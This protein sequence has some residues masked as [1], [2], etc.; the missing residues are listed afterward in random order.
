M[1]Q[2]VVRMRRDAVLVRSNLEGVEDVTKSLMCPPFEIESESVIQPGWEIEL[3]EFDDEWRA[4]GDK[5]TD[6]RSVRLSVSPNLEYVLRHYSR[7]LVMIYAP[8]L[9]SL[10][11]FAVES[12]RADKRWTIFADRGGENNY[13]CVSRMVQLYFGS[14]FQSRG[15]RFLHSSA[16]S[17]NGHGVSFIGSGASGKTSLM[18]LA[19]SKL[20]ASFIADDQVLVG[21]DDSGQLQI[22]GWPRRVAVG[23]SL[24][25]D[26]P[27]LEKL[28]NATLRRAGFAY[29]RM[30]ASI[31]DEWT[32]SN[33][34]ALDQDEFL[35]MSGFHAVPEAPLSLI[36]IP[37]VDRSV[38][39]WK[40]EHIDG[41]YGRDLI[42]KHFDPAEQVRYV[43]DYLGLSNHVPVTI[44]NTNIE[45]ISHV[46]RVRVIIGRSVKERFSEFWGD[47]VSYSGLRKLERT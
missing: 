38:R 12:R 37:T 22:Q 8:P 20:N 11:H 16:V 39:S 3:R 47:L 26:D 19:C 13:R 15:S 21:E 32:E 28:R 14:L 40:F 5:H 44:Y 35:Y 36:V 17:V 6:M 43:T 1:E 23:L 45:A 29:H 30:P 34:V 42:V 31:S 18:Y 33:K 25:I 46:P 41:S 9:L 24:L 7:D 27:M 10:P 4:F 2:F